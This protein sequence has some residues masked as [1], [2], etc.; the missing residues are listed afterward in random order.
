MSLQRHGQLVR[1]E[2]MLHDS[3]SW[4]T[5]NLPGNP[6]QAFPQQPMGYPNDV[7]AHMNRSQQQAYMQQQQA[8]A[9]QRGIGPSPSKRPR[10]GTQGSMHGSATAIPAPMV[11][12]DPSLDDEDGTVGGDYMDFLTPRDISLHRYIQHHEWLEE[13]LES[14][15]DT[16]QIVPGDLGLGRKGELESLTRDFFEAPVD[17][18][19]K[20]KFDPKEPPRPVDEVVIPRVG[21]LEAGKA[22][23]FTQRASEKVAQ[24]NEQMEKLRRQHARRMA[25]LSKGHSIKE[26]T[27]ELRQQ[28]NEIISGDLKGLGNNQYQSMDD[29]ALATIG[30]PVQPIQ[31]IKCVQK[32]GLEEKADIKPISDHDFDMVDNFN[33]DGASDER[34]AASDQV[35]PAQADPVDSTPT[36]DPSPQAEPAN[37]AKTDENIP[38]QS[39]PTD[40]STGAAEDWVMVNKESNSPN[41]D[42]DQDLGLMDQFTNDAEDDPDATT[43]EFIQD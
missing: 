38:E 32:G 25:K 23:D 30:K 11:P 10:H 33:F 29:L 39:V 6:N 43:L 34:P 14:P 17:P 1:K 5:I 41:N 7:M 42:Q 31:D 40:Q 4:P 13:I 28:T 15:Y 35:P 19:P 20:E 16:N 21:R 8:N 37:P 22:D 18:T 27:K 36:Q 24:I 3:A 12:Q 9:S 2:F 26:A